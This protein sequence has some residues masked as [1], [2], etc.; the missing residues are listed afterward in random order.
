[1][2]MSMQLVKKDMVYLITSLKSVII[3]G[4]VLALCLPFANIGFGIA[5]PALCTYLV[6]YSIMA[7]EERSKVMLLNISL[8]VTRKALCRAKYIEAFLF[9]I[10]NTVLATVGTWVN[11]LVGEASYSGSFIELIEPLV[12]T[13]LVLG[14][15]YIGVILP[16]IFHFGTTKAK[17][18]LMVTYIIIFVGASNIGKIDMSSVFG[19]MEV[20]LGS[21]GQI[22]LILIA[23]GALIISYSISLRIFEKKDFA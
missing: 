19:N 21:F 8:P 15:I 14:G 5:M 6:V 3:M 17:L 20:L 22:I 12:V 10:I 1:M 13:M 16:L 2:G 7:Y 23:V 9:I 11:Y 4:I 18:I